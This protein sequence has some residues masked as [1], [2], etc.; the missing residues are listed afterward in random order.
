MTGRKGL[1]RAMGITVVLSVLVLGSVCVGVNGQM[2]RP[3]MFDVIQ[4]QTGIA[5]VSNMYNSVVSYHTNLTITKPPAVGTVEV[6]LTAN[7]SAGFV[8]TPRP[9]HVVFVQPGSVPITIDVFVPKGTPQ[10]DNVYVN[11]KGVASSPGSTYEGAA[12]AKLVVEQYYLGN[13]SLVNKRRDTYMTEYIIQVENT[14]NGNDTFQLSIHNASKGLNDT[15]DSY[16][17]LAE[18][19][20][21]APGETDLITMKVEYE[22]G[23]E[24]TSGD[25]W[26]VMRSFGAV[27]AGKDHYEPIMVEIEVPTVWETELVYEIYGVGFLVIFM[28]MAGVALMGQGMRRK[29]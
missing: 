4:P 3:P 20:E 21:L 6:N 8:A 28:I 15:I 27:L 7:C 9:D 29:D 5:N 19:R 17:E 16:F 18:T 1:A 14:G 13:I 26:L 2:L 23:I 11:L 22:P 24:P 12:R 10:M 25:I